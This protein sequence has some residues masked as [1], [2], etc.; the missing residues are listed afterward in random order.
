MTDAR[1]NRYVSV[2]TMPTASSNIFGE[3]CLASFAPKGA[4]IT[5]PNNSP[6]VAIVK[7]SAPRDRKKVALIASVRKTST[8]L[9]VPMVMRGLAPWLHR[10]GVTVGTHPPPP[11]EPRTPHTRHRRSTTVGP[12]ERG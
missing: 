1:P 5:P 3:T 4:A 7:V 9:T 10:L 6:T 11:D 12:Q 2:S 8:A